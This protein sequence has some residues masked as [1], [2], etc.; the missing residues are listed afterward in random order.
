MCSRIDM[1]C[2]SRP[3]AGSRLALRCMG[4]H[5]RGWVGCRSHRGPLIG[6]VFHFCA[7][8]SSGPR[9]GVTLC[10]TVAP[11]KGGDLSE[12]AAVADQILRAPGSGVMSP[13]MSRPAATAD[14][15]SGSTI[16]TVERAVDVLF[17]I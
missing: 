7:M 16:A 15:M 6:T 4:A 14:A 1:L 12:S 5:R 9:K 11:D 17:H 8:T 2:R 3:T 13:R 10:G